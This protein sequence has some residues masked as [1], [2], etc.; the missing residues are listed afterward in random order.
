M[1]LYKLRNKEMLEDR[2]LNTI[3]EHNLINT[4]ECIVLGVSGGPDST[5]LFHIFLKLQKELNFTFV[6]AHVNH[7][8][9]KEAIEDEEYVKDLCKKNEITCYIKNSDILSLSKTE[10]IGVEEA[11]RK[12]RYEFFEEIAGKVGASKIAT[13]HNKNDKVETVLMN[14]MRGSGISRIKRNTICKRK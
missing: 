13:A 12:I 3:K 9:R 7:G 5:C 4:S 8:I 1:K 14:M 2:V 11:G 6:V 10:K